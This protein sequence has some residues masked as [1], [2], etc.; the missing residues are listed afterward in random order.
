MGDMMYQPLF[1]WCVRRFDRSGLASKPARLTLNFLCGLSTYIM[2]VSGLKE[3]AASIQNRH[4][5]Y[6]HGLTH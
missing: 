4:G 3:E 1:G 2:T 5:P 6:C